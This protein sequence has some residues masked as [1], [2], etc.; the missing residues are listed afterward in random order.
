MS[1]FEMYVTGRAEQLYAL[2]P[3]LQRVLEDYDHTTG[4]CFKPPCVEEN[5]DQIPIEIRSTYM[6]Q[7]KALYVAIMAKL[8]DNVKCLTK[9]TFDY[10]VDDKPA[11]C[12]ENDGPNLLFALICMFRPCNVEYTEQLESLLMDAHIEFKGADPR[13]VIKDLRKPLQE[14]QTLQIPLRWKQC[15]KRIVDL[16]IHNDHNM[17]DALASFKSVQ[18]ADKDCTAMLDKLFAA[19]EAQCKRNDKHDGKLSAF[20]MRL[21]S[22]KRDTSQ[23]ECKFGDNCDRFPNCGY[24]HSNSEA[25]ES[26]QGKGGVTRENRRGGKGAKGDRGNA[27]PAKCLGV[28]CPDKGSKNKILCTTCFMKAC[29]DGEVKLKDGSTFVPKKARKPF[30]SKGKMQDL[31]KA[32]AALTE[33]EPDPEEIDDDAPTGVGGPACSDKNKRKRANTAKSVSD[34][35]K[36]IKDFAEE[37]GINFN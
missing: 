35:T 17:H 31:K 19:V 33:D 34:A 4:A 16:L 27:Q 10:G 14:A 13:D 1:N 12:A 8:S 26:E 20:S 28:G 23:M 18:V 6:S 29:E 32:F 21:H 15:G 24:L 7:S 9:A 30:M 37:L 11:L 22:N 3:F 2:M 36:R 5:T 25:N